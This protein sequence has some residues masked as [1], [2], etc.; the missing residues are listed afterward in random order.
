MLRFYSPIASLSVNKEA[1]GQLQGGSDREDFWFPGDKRWMQGK[2]R[3]FAML[4][5]EKSQAII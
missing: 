2:R 4:Q 5:R 1:M 3:E